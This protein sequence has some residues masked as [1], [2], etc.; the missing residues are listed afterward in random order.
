MQTK[1][2]VDNRGEGNSLPVKKTE[3]EIEAPVIGENK[4][5]KVEVIAKALEGTTGK[6][7]E[8]VEFEK[9][10]WSYN[11]EENKVYIEVENKKEVV[12]KESGDIIKEEKVTEEELYY[13]KAGV[14]EYIVTYTYENVRKEEEKIG[15]KI[16]AEQEMFGEY[17][18]GNEIEAEY[19]V[20]E[21]IGNIVTYETESNIE[22]VSKGN[23]YYGNEVEIEN[24]LI[25]NISYK[26][27]VESIR[28]EDIKNTYV[29]K[30]GEEVENKDVYY[31]EI[32]INKNNFKE[33]LGEEGSI[34]I[35]N[36][37]GSLIRTIN[38]DTEEVE[39][40]YIVKFENEKIIKIETTK[41]VADGNMII[42]TVR[43][44]KGTEYEKEEY[45]NFEKLSINTEGK[46]KYTY[47]E[48]LV[49]CGEQRTEIK[50]EDTVSKVNLKIGQENLSTLV[51]N[52]NVELKLELNNENI[53]S[54]IYG[55][56]EIEIK[57]PEYVESV[58]ITDRS[59]VYGE[60]LELS[61]I[62][63]YEKE[64]RI[65]LK[66]T[67][68][69]KQEALS[70]GIITNGTNIVMNANIKVNMYAPAKEEKFEVRY[71]NSE[72]TGY[73]QEEEGKGYSEAKVIYSAPKGLLTINS[74]TGYDEKGSKV[75]SVN[76]GKQTDKIAI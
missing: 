16:K 11:K 48:E 30:T 62:E 4:A 13:S 67:I 74:I 5:E 29:K 42:N 6:I 63:G 60:G 23:T 38:K 64:G 68:T 50:L 72:A 21:Q 54:D 58:E 17:S 61:N 22:K 7:N 52:K 33:I 19:E 71:E 76:Q 45:K 31:K 73:E 43:G 34:K 66:I 35:Y 41:P 57:M 32:R 65:Y 8:E 69:G 14:D 55:N 15:T 27:I 56:T 25:F 75:V 1:V 53:T 3:I 47:I 70:S 36:E 40:N 2:K 10:N 20:R 28:Y 39:E 51:E 59:I 44:Y 49:D 26:D 46:A 12:A 18:I 9:E 24:K 37:E